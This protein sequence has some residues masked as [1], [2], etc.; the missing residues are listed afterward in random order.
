M[1][2]SM[3]LPS[4][5]TPSLDR[6]A[7]RPRRSSLT[8]PDTLKLGDDAH[9][10]VTAPETKEGRYIN[11]PFLSMIANIAA[12]PNFDSDLEAVEKAAPGEDVQMHGAMG[13]DEAA[14]GNAYSQSVKIPQKV[15]IRGRKAGQKSSS[16][17]VLSSREISGSPS[18]TLKEDMNSSQIL[19]P[20][21][22]GHDYR[23]DDMGP[24]QPEVG[25]CHTTD[26]TQT[27]DPSVGLDDRLAQIFGFE[28][29][30]SVVSGTATSPME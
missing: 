12:N 30:E 23:L 18:F 28:Q 26:G 5:A 13:R 1:A 17:K 8:L 19:D 11:Q 14:N 15:A 6:A 2:Q 3:L 16:T 21:R 9:E 27:H 10:D 25:E 4:S 7:T 20:R 24:D 29:I 22:A